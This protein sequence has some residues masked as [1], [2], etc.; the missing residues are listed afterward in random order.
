MTDQK[1]IECARLITNRSSA[2]GL[3][4]GIRGLSILWLLVLAWVLRAAISL[5]SL[6]IL[7]LLGWSSIRVLWWLIISIL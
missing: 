1:G 3:L 2:I 4:I 5:L 6:L 7:L